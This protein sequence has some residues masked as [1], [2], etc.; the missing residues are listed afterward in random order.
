MSMTDNIADMLTRIRNGQLARLISVSMPYSKMKE[1]IIAVLTEQGYLESYEV[2]G[3]TVNK[4]IAVELRYSKDGRPA[5]TEIAKVSKPGK[6]E[7][8]GCKDIKPYYNNLGIQILS[9]PKGIL[10]DA[11]ARE[12]G[13]GGEIICK[14]F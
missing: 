7:Y 14:V 13:V 4:E 3:D 12:K 6:R 5:I 11:E 8:V 9:T 10:T 1:S 2:S